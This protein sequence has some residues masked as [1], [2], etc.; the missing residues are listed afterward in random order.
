MLELCLKKIKRAMDSRDQKDLRS[1][2]NENRDRNGKKYESGFHLTAHDDEANPYTHSKHKF[3]LQTS[4]TH[5]SFHIAAQP[6][7]YKKS[8][9][10][11]RL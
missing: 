4:H 10:I 1:T 6:N 11:I 5:T 3:P 8:I 7:N 9:W 2:L